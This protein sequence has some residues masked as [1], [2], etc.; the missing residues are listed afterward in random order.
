MDI[1]TQF[2]LLSNLTDNDVFSLHE[3][4]LHVAGLLLSSYHSNRLVCIYGNGGSADA[5]HF[6]AE[7]VATFDKFSR[8]PLPVVSLTTDT[9]FITAWS[10]DYSFDQIFSRQIQAF[11]S[12]LFLSIGL[13]TSGTSPNV[14]TGLKLSHSLGHKTI[15]ITGPILLN[16]VLLIISF[17]FLQLPLH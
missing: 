2:S 1:R 5:Q 9:S 16:I 14:L 6:S 10:N 13:S 7:L 4:V 8:P 12:L 15:L 3:S 17:V 11:Q